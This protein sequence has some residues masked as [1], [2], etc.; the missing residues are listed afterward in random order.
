MEGIIFIGIQASGKSSFYL[1]RFF[2]THLRLNLDMLRTRNRERI[3]LRA[4]IQA[5]QPVVI[6]NTNPTGADRADYIRAFKDGGFRVRG[7]YFQSALPE[8]LARNRLRKKREKIPDAAL[9]STF[10]RL[11]LPGYEE[12]FDALY[13]VQLADDDFVV[14]DW[15]ADIR[16]PASPDCNPIGEDP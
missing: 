5:Q 16:Y 14:V 13:H 11:E 4:C 15:Q 7:F 10:K 3:L 1:K 12:G 8:C 2:Q 9:F 6:D